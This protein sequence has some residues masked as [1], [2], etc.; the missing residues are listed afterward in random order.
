MLKG[1]VK[2]SNPWRAVKIVAKRIVTNKAKEA[3]FFDPNKIAWWAHV[4]DA[5]ELNNNIV[6]NK[7]TCQGSNVVK[8]AG[9]HM[10][11]SAGLGLKLEW[12][13]AQKKPKKNITSD[14]MNNTT[15]NFNP[16]WTALVCWP[17]KVLSR[18][19]SR[20]QTN[21]TNNIIKNPNLHKN[22]PPTY[23]CI[24]KALP[25]VNIQAENAAVIGHGLGSTKW[26]G[27]PVFVKIFI[28]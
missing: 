1:A 15:P 19:I 13:K 7:G 3:S 8:Y 27:C 28:I 24:V 23:P 6:F 17:S 18:T 11:P 25:K 16:F 10:P 20:H 2:Y 14:N 12:K 22:K 21:I 5:P 4:T 26:K 9:G